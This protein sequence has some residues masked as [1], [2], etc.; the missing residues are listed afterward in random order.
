[1]WIIFAGTAKP[2]FGSNRIYLHEGHFRLG[3]PCWGVD[4]GCQVDGDDYY[5]PNLTMYASWQS[6]ERKWVLSRHPGF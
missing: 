6:S 2:C 3:I 4:V 5:E 1:M